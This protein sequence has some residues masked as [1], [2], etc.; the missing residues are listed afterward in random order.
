[1]ETSVK[2]VLADLR[3]T[4]DA[5]ALASGDRLPSERELRNVFGCSREG[6]VT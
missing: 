4:L 3:A 6:D 5:L 1:M 2:A